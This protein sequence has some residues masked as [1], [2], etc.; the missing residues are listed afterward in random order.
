MKMKKRPKI[1]IGKWGTG[2]TT[3]TKIEIAGRDY[4]SYYASDIK[5]DDPYS[6]QDNLMVVIEE[7]NIKPQKEIIMGL[8]HAGVDLV[9]TSHNKK[10]VP[11][12][13]INACEVKMCGS[14]N[15]Y[16]NLYSLTCK[17]M[18][19]YVSFDDSIWNVMSV[20][21]K[22][23]NR[24]KFYRDLVN[25]SPPPMQLISWAI[26]TFP[27]N[28]RLQVVSSMMNRLSK[29]YFYAIFAYSWDG[30]YRKIIPPQRKVNNPYPA[31]AVKLGFKADETY[32]LKRL[33]REEPYANF[34]SSKLTA[35]ECRLIGV[36]KKKRPTPKIRPRKK[37]E[38]F[39]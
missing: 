4:V 22:S 35:A 9:L 30:G 34:V 36:T 1:F 32:I 26:A 21:V 17:N 16:Q 8:I 10:D 23:K 14:K 31:I 11:K 2:K 7:V 18:E 3:K 39:I 25:L 5:I 6:I 27:E 24:D 28:S 13:I 38:D 37:L 20:Y 29:D 12:E 15:R 33:I 19:K